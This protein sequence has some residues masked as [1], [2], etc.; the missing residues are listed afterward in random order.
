MIDFIVPVGSLALFIPRGLG[1]VTFEMM[2]ITISCIVLIIGGV[3]LSITFKRRSRVF[4]VQGALDD[5]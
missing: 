5:R 4:S 2:A 1:L 3:L